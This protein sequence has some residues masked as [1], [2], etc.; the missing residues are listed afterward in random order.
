MSAQT[1]PVGMG[2]SEAA[3]SRHSMFSQSLARLQ[4]L[5]W[6]A[7]NFR[8][9]S[10]KDFVIVCI[11]VDSPW[12]DLVDMLMPNTPEACWNDFRDKGMPPV[13][14]GS[15]SASVCEFVAKRCPGIQESL[16]EDPDDDLVKCLALDE[17]GCTI[18]EIKPIEIS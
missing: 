18:Y 15:A 4:H 2:F 3:E 8:N 1:T 7:I 5:A 6:R 17:G 12:R 14:I 13:A 11:K 9:L 16:R 10:N